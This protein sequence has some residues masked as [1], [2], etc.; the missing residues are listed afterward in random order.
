M[1]SDNAEVSGVDLLLETT[2]VMANVERSIQDLMRLHETAMA[3]MREHHTKET[4]HWTRLKL[5]ADLVDKLNGPITADLARIVE[6]QRTKSEADAER[7][8]QQEGAMKWLGTKHGI[9]AVAAVSHILSQLFPW[10]T[11]ITDMISSGA[12]P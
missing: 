5:Q 11:P 8:K 1:P 4:E 3:E 12:T 7:A 10:M 9:A 2:L 6:A